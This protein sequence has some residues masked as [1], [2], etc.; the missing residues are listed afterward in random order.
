MNAE[1]MAVRSGEARWTAAMTAE[2]KVSPTPAPRTGRSHPKSR[3]EAS[4]PQRLSPAR[5]TA[6]SSS[7][8][9]SGGRG[10]YRAYSAPAAGAAGTMKPEADRNTRPAPVADQ[11]RTSC[12]YSVRKKIPPKSPRLAAKQATAAAEVTG[13]RSTRTSSMGAGAR[14]S[15]TAKAGSATT[16]KASV[17]RI[18]GA[19]QP[20]TGPWTRAYTR[21]PRPV[22]ASACPAGSQR[23]GAGATRGS[24]RRARSIRTAP[25]GRLIHITLRQPNASTSGPPIVGPRATPSP[26]APPRTPMARVRRASSVKTCRSRPMLAGIRTAAPSP[27]TT[28]PVTRVAQSGASALSAEPAQ[29][30]SMPPRKARRCPRR[31]PRTLPESRKAAKTRV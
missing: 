9:S 13:S 29:K 11:W 19:V 18:A 24:T 28:R 26:P 5:D 21:L 7:P 17:A 4:R 1:V 23:A 16:A 8:Q 12:R 20:S 3:K 25:T 15:T 27:W 30:A 22:T 31:T 2:T 6:H 10:P 14:H